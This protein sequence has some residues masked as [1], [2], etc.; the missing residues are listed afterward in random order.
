M[1]KEEIIFELK[2]E[3]A[4]NM[5]D[6]VYT[7][8]ES[9]LDLDHLAFNNFK[10]RLKAMDLFDMNGAINLLNT[11]GFKRTDLIKE[12]MLKCYLD[13]DVS[14]K[15]KIV[16]IYTYLSNLPNSPLLVCS[17]PMGIIPV[18]L[19]KKSILEDQTTFKALQFY[20]L[21]LGTLY[22]LDGANYEPVVSSKFLDAPK[23]NNKKGKKNNKKS[24]VKYLVTKKYIIDSIKTE[25]K[26]REYT[27]PSWA[28]K[29]YWRKYPSGKR[30]WIEPSTRKRKSLINEK[31]EPTIIKIN[32]TIN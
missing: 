7:E 18:P 21:V 2:T 14:I 22:Q 3:V 28:V 24:Y 12:E 17:I 1:K 16:D 13:I 31:D 23:G 29:G 6:K 10:I 8:F 11:R 4:E 27:K 19:I 32:H 20:K 9:K 25:P 15:D 5:L 26:E 30:V